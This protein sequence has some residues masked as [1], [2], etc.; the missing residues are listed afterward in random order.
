MWFVFCVSM[1]LLGL[2]LLVMGLTDS[3]YPTS[4]RIWTALGTVQFAFLAVRA[5]QR[6]RVMQVR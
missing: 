1:T 4:V 5:Y 6:L 2:V 3:T